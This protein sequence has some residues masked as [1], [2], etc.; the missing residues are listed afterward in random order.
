MK[1]KSTNNDRIFFVK[2]GNRLELNK[3]L[4]ELL[5][6][7]FNDRFSKMGMTDRAWNE[8][9]VKWGEQLEAMKAR[10]QEVISDYKRILKHDNPK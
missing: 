5:Q 2:K 1:D 7:K 10:Y 3:P 8:M 4:G 9:T 6:K